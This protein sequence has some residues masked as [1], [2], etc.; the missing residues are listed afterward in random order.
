MAPLWHLP[1]PAATT[2]MSPEDVLLRKIQNH[3]EFPT[4]VHRKK[5]GKTLFYD[6]NCEGLRVP[7]DSQRNFCR[8]RKLRRT[9][10]SRRHQLECW[11]ISHCFSQP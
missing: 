4:K 3:P 9:S 10:D 6:M 5:E 1:D 11:D 7:A 2:D 8:S